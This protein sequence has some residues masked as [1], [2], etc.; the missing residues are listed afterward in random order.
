MYE[1][2]WSCSA[3]AMKDEGIHDDSSKDET[4]D[5]VI[6]RW[7]SIPSMVLFLESPHGTIPM[8][9]GKT[10]CCYHRMENKSKQ[11]LVALENV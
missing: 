5:V 1:H 8:L 2:K 9:Y 10:Q 4:K 11:N 3:Y 6:K 7:V